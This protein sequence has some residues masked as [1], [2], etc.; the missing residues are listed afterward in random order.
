VKVTKSGDSY[1]V[2]TNNNVE[3]GKITI[4][5]QHKAD[6]NIDID[7]DSNHYID[8]NNSLDDKSDNSKVI[9]K[10][11]NEL[12]SLMSGLILVNY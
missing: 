5:S 1:I 6:N 9:S 4:L 3:L 11:Q 12:A 2:K 7:L 8:I 10:S